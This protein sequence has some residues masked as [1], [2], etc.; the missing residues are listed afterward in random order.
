[1]SKKVNILG[2]EYTIETENDKLLKLNADGLCEQYTK[3]ICVRETDSFLT[4]DDSQE[5]KL[6]REKEVLRHELY[7]AFFNESGL[8]DDYS[9]NE[10]L[11]N[12]LA[13]QSP[14]IFKVFQELDV[15]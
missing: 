9:G 13:I 10:Q 15:L 6:V 1:M 11:I 12:W 7:H 3:K 14:K 2:T 5:T 4:D 8:S